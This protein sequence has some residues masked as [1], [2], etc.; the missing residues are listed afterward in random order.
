MYILQFK[1]C[2]GVIGHAA[3]R[4]DEDPYEFW[5]NY[6]DR[7][8]MGEPMDVRVAGVGPND[9]IVKV[10]LAYHEGVEQN[11]PD[12]DVNWTV[13]CSLFL[14]CEHDIPVEKD[15]V[16][17]SDLVLPPQKKLVLP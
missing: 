17:Q 11:L 4:E 5:A 6:S 14:L 13:V 8:A 12:K 15:K 2:N 7:L 1:A 3:L 16:V 10:T 9:H